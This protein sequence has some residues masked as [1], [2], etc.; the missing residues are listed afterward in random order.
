MKEYFSELY[1]VYP[2]KLSN[3]KWFIYATKELDIKEVY[4]YSKLRYEYVDN[5]SPILSHDCINIR[6]ILEVDFFVK[7]YMRMYGIDKVRGGSYTNE[8]LSIEEQK[9]LTKEIN[10]KYKNVDKPV[11]TTIIEYNN[12]SD[13]TIEEIQDRKKELLKQR[14]LY[15]F[16]QER[17][18]KFMANL[19]NTEQPLNHIILSDIEWLNNITEFLINNYFDNYNNNNIMNEEIYEVSDIIKN[20]YKSTRK[21]II[22]LNHKFNEVYDNEEYLYSS[23]EMIEQI[24]KNLDDL[25][26]ITENSININEIIINKENTFRQLEYMYYSLKNIRDGYEFDKDSYPENFEAITEWKLNKLENI[27]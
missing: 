6:D 21:N 17:Y 1:Y 23:I 11:D 13:W 3:K 25:F 15:K 7:K 27:K 8:I 16:E 4:L 14:E 26:T 12:L 18:N 10:Q 24:I 9:L 20:T 22:G 19:Y 5:N 2:L